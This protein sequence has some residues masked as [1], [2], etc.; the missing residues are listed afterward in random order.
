MND[1]ETRGEIAK[2]LADIKTQISDESLVSKDRYEALCNKLD[3]VT[4]ENATLK[5]EIVKLNKKVNEQQNEIH[6]L[7]GCVNDLMQER[8][9]N[10]VVIKGVQEVGPEEALQ[11]LVPVILKELNVEVRNFEVL[12][13]RR[14]G[15]P[16]AGKK[17]PIVVT[18]MANSIKSKIIRAKRLKNL[19][20]S[21]FSCADKPIGKES[22]KIY[23]DEHLT[24]SN[25][26][27]F[28]EARKLRSMGVKFVWTRNGSVLMRRKENEK[29]VR[30]RDFAQLSSIFV[31]LSRAA[32]PN[33]TQGREKRKEISPTES[34]DDETA[35]E[36]QVPA[37][38][39]GKRSKNDEGPITVSDAED[40]HLSFTKRLDEVTRNAFDSGEDN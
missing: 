20:A 33:Q 14:I 25:M 31:G 15:Q 7:S 1:P 36:V 38:Q 32:T 13:V 2:M 10:N 18:L 29:I 39:K 11:S 6:V 19:N 40:M 27:L 26:Q 22:E 37:I 16:E 21:M 35:S 34:K 17:R 3:E 5:E 30:I 8:I 28:M 24:R 12:S 23:I 4:K 9:K